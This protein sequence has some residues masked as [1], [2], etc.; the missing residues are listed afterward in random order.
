MKCVDK[1][2]TCPQYKALCSSNALFNGEPLKKVCARTCENCKSQYYMIDN[3][4]LQIIFKALTF[5][6]EP[7]FCQNETFNC[8]NGG[9]CKN[10]TDYNDDDYIAYTCE[11][12]V[13]YSGFLCE[14][15]QNIYHKF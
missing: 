2:P 8:K 7:L 15:S 1:H 14:L 10:T 6:E 12:P 9:K 4:F 11:C 3:V 5:K 13:G